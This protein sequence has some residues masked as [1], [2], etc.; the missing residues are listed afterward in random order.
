[1]RRGLSALTVPLPTRIASYSSR[2]ARLR[3]RA[4]SDV[5]H[6]DSRA[7]VASLPSSVIAAFTSTNGSFCVTDQTNF[8]FSRRA[9]DSSTPVD[10]LDARRA[11]RRDA[12]AVHE[13]VRIAHRDDHARHARRRS[14]PRR[15]AACVR[16]ASTAR[17]SRT[18]S[19]RARR[20]SARSASISAC[21]SPARSCHPSAIDDAVAHDHAADHRIGADGVAALLRELE[22]APHELLVGHC[23]AIVWRATAEAALRSCTEAAASKPAVRRASIRLTA[24]AEAGTSRRRC[25]RAS[26]WTRTCA[27]AGR[28]A[29]GR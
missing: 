24:P 26:A 23:G 3:S 4:A 28:C 19:R 22:S 12:A 21:A 10:D 8:S 18:S 27:R 9:S 5:I 16:D 13:L 1:M 2:S 6:C 15:T 7:T 29:R 17:A 20:R 14:P 11:Q 25:R